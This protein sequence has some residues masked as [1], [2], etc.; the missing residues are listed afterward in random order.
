VSAPEIYPPPPPEP[1]HLVSRVVVD[2]EGGLEAGEA[3]RFGGGLHRALCDIGRVTVA[4]TAGGGLGHVVTMRAPDV[5]PLLEVETVEVPA[6]AYE[7]ALELLRDLRDHP[8]FGSPLDAQTLYR[9]NVVELA[10]DYADPAAQARAL[11][12]LQARAERG[13]GA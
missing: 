4:L 9:L 12:L 11:E 2:F 1:S 5:A 6:V 10:L 8:A 3:E 13:G 7:A